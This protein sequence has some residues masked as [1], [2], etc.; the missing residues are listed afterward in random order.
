MSTST[1]SNVSFKTRVHHKKLSAL[2]WDERKRPDGD[3][4]EPVLVRLAPLAGAV[5]ADKPPVRIYVGTEPAQ[6]RA[7]RVFV[8]SIVKH[9]DPGRAYE[10]YLMG[11]LQGFDRSTWKTGFTQYRYAIP[12]LTGYRGRAIYNDV[13]QIYL[14]DPAELFDVDM[15]QAAVLSI[16]DKETSV[17]LLDCAKLENVWTLEMAQAPGKHKLFRARVRDAGLWGNMDPAWN[18]RDDEYVAGRSKLLHFTTLHTQPWQ[19]F[20]EVLRYRPHALRAVWE[21]LEAEADAARF[22]LFSAAS[23]SPRYQQL[24]AFYGQ[25]H[26]EGRPETGHSAAST[27]SGISLTEHVGPIAKLIAEH[28]AATVLDYGSGKGGLYQPAPGADPDSRFKSM[29]CWQNAVIT[30]YDPGYAPFA[31]PYEESYDG[32]I[33]TDVLEHI[34]A[35]DIGWALHHL[36]GTARKFVYAVAACYPAKKLMPDGSNAHC[37]IRSPQWWVGQM[38][39]VA[40]AYPGVA[41]TLCTQEKSLL[42]FQQRKKLYKQ[43]IRNRFF[44]HYSA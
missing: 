5:P 42:A 4:A 22:T 41:W 1:V 39:M 16:N 28:G 44:H 30:C 19:P 21:Q 43:G 8:W 27:F 25:M 38:R 12:A 10:I 33:T 24:L 15:Q 3:R 20:P 36:F 7:E 14:T 11:D 34:P 37:T 31:G 6:Y 29:P 35:E 2:L 18:A 17:M 23:P 40:K 26:E 32:V 9:R 13:D